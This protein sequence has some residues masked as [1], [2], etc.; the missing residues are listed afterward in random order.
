MN[1]WRK[2]VL[3]GWVFFL[4]Y[5]HAGEFITR[6][7]LVGGEIDSAGIFDSVMAFS[8]VSSELIERCSGTKI[9]KNTILTAAHCFYEELELGKN[10]VI[11]R[12]T[13]PSWI[14]Y[15]FAPVIMNSSTVKKISIEKIFFHP[16]LESCFST[17]GDAQPVCVDKF[18]DLAI[19]QVEADE[20]FSKENLSL[21]D[22]KPVSEGESVI[23]VG[24][25]AQTDNDSNPPV[26]KFHRSRVVPLEELVKSHGGVSPDEFEV[27]K[28]LYF[29]TW[30]LLMGPDHANLGAGDSGGPVFTLKNNVPSLIGVNSFSYC[31]NEEVDCEVTSNSYFT[32][33][34]AG[35]PHNLGEWISDFLIS[36][37]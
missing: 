14:F 32:R 8:A 9:G 30:G 35:S 24:F 6:P 22:L 28:E 15:S 4:P 20:S 5:L 13:A 21:I 1:L 10:S 36:K 18:P 26:R 11:K 19:I 31:Q 34:H 7:F 29:G 27:Y 33:V 16:E 23:M 37:N 12:N 2:V 25:G 17:S 3:S